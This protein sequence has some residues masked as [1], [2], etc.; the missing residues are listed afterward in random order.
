MTVTGER[1]LQHARD[2]AASLGNVTHG[3]PFTVHL[4][5]WKV[6]N[7]VFL[8]VT[9]NDPDLQ[10]FTVKAEPHRGD[11]LRRDFATITIGRY[12]NKQ[13]WISI[14]PGVGITKQLIADLVHDSHD[15]ADQRHRKQ[16]P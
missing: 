8:I 10:I 5:V 2:I 1:L 12:L 6:H 9:D 11:A 7:K 16:Q 15:L 13:Q 3:R 4:D 14:G